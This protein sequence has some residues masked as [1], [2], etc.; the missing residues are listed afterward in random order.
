V[1]RH[2]DMWLQE[3]LVTYLSRTGNRGDEDGRAG[4]DAIDIID[5]A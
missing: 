1:R 4:M 3:A 5:A 2:Q